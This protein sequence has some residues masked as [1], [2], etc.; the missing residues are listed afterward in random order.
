MTM[1]P[2]TSASA[3][4]ASSVNA[5]MP[6]RWKRN[7]SPTVAWTFHSTMRQKIVPYHTC[8]CSLSPNRDHGARRIASATMGNATIQPATIQPIGNA[9]AVRSK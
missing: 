9:T 6:R 2:P 8:T 5:A 3:G 4:P 7:P 1:A